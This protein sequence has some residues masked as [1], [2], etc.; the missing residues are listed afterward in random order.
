VWL[1]AAGAAA[2]A[3]LVGLVALAVVMAPSRGIASRVGRSSQPGN[4]PA[5]MPAYAAA[6]ADLVIAFGSPGTAPGQMTDPRHVAVDPAGNVFVSD[7]D[8]GRVQKLD[9]TGKSLLVVQVPPDAN[10][11]RLVQGLAA[12]RAGRVYVSRG[13]DLLQYSA[14]DGRLLATFP[15]DFPRTRYDAVCVDAAGTVWAL[16]TT[17]SDND[18]I[19]LDASGKVLGRWGRIVSGVNPKDSAMSLELAVDAR[20][21]VFV[22]SSFGKQVYAYDAAVKPTGRFGADVFTSP[23]A[24]A[25][26]AKGR[27][28]VEDFGDIDVFGPTRQLL[29]RLPKDQRHGAVA[30]LTIGPTGELYAVTH[31][32]KVLKYRMREGR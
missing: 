10:G 27:V 22:S 16:H 6:P 20:G 1:A 23:G 2:L 9:P 18:L 25:V 11:L 26:D 4:P 12:D 29:Y 32:A 8:T 13:G 15:H 31:G 7:F 30:G 3:V 17:A 24:I 5:T 28:F 14:A 19:R 21:G